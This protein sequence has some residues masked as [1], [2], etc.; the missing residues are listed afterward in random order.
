MAELRKYGVQDKIYFPLITKD[1]ADFLSGATHASGDT[2]IIKDGGTSANTTNA[3]VDE[4]NGFYSLTLTAT[5]MQAAVI[6]VTIIDQG[7]KDFEDQAVLIDTYGNASGQ[8][9]FDLDTATQAVDVLS[10]SG[11]TTAADNMEAYFDGTG[12]APAGFALR[13]NAATA[14]AAG[15]LTLDASAPNTLDYYKNCILVITSGTGVGQAR[16][17]T[18]YSTGRVATVVPNWTVTPGTTSGYM[19]IPAGRMDVGL[20]AGSAVNA[21]VSGRV[22]SSTGAMASGV[23]TGAAIGATAGILTNTGTASAVASTTIT[24][25]ASAIATADYYIGQLIT[26]TGGTTGAGQVR[27]ITAYTSGRVATIDPA[28]TVTPTGTITYTVTPETGTDSV[29][30]TAAAI[31]D[32]VWDEARAG[33]VAAGSFGE[34]VPADVSLVSGDATAA[35]NLEAMF[36]G[37]GYAGGTIKLGVDTV[38]VSGDTVAADNL[39]AAYDGAG[40][41]GGTIKQLVDVAAISGDTT[42]ADNAEAM[43]DGTGYAGGTIKLGVDAVAIS[44]SAT[45]ADNL[46]RGALAAVLGAAVSGTLS[47]TQMS[48][49]LTEATNDHYKDRMLIWTTGSLAGV[50]VKITAYNG[51]TKVITYNAT[52][53]GESPSDGDTFIIV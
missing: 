21:L 27:K 1:A 6:C 32:A 41:A 42:A 49:G 10:V 38:A 40:Y 47:S 24:L 2:K 53:T 16:Q 48:T 19:I 26:I 44:G 30:P 9:A 25:A 18:G 36:D 12:Y 43:F 28:W 20:W 23:L 13:A 5:E 51:T 29:V 45:A 37:T 39:E 46:E 8:H 3:F 35:A 4:G 50:A 31:A 14:S 34:Y 22:D 11:D 33:H 52:P 15:S 7:T 17:I